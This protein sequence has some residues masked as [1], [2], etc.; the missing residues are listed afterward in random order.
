M[1]SESVQQWTFKW[2]WP[3]VRWPPLF[4]ILLIRTRSSVK[5]CTEEN[6][7]NNN[8]DQ[9]SISPTVFL[10][11]T[12]SVFPNLF[13]FIAIVAVLVVVVVILF[14]SSNVQSFVDFCFV[15]FYFCNSQAVLIARTIFS[16]I[17]LTLSR[18]PRLP[19]CD[20]L[21][22]A[23]FCW[24]AQLENER[25]DCFKNLLVYSWEMDGSCRQTRETFS[26]WLTH[27]H[28]GRF[29]ILACYVQYIALYGCDTWLLHYE[30][31]SEWVGAKWN[32]R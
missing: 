6:I 21:V 15:L 27:I 2:T 1:C 11:Q 16:I 32:E 4:S 17:S 22:F 12:L 26:I 13:G 29:Q 19:I 31:M 25:N 5:S 7:A 20:S 30:R 9:L 14:T 23:R 24:S 10:S 28:N 18:T 3:V 8:F